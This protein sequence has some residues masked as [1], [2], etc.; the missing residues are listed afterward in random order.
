MTSSPPTL[1]PWHEG[2][3][4][5]PYPW[6]FLDYLQLPPGTIEYCKM[7]AEADPATITHLNDIVVSDDSGDEEAPWSPDRCLKCWKAEC[8]IDGLTICPAC[9]DDCVFCP[10]CKRK[11]LYEQSCWVC[12]DPGCAGIGI[13]FLF[14]SGCHHLFNDGF[15]TGKYPYCSHKCFEASQT[16]S[17]QKDWFYDGPSLCTTCKHTIENGLVMHSAPFCSDECI[18]KF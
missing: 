11:T 7:I 2:I 10:M 9:T 3:P 6:N 15:I 1:P 13:P 8:R 4:H 12:A 14:C 16:Y 18:T 17:G 5:S